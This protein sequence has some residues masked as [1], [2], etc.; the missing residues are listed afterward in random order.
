MVLL[1]S[2]PQLLGISP[3]GT[4][5]H[6][7]SLWTNA[8]DIGAGIVGAS[9]IRRVVQQIGIEYVGVSNFTLGTYGFVVLPQVLSGVSDISGTWLTRD[10]PGGA[11]VVGLMPSSLWDRIAT[12]ID[13][14]VS[15]VGLVDASPAHVEFVPGT[16][17]YLGTLS[18]GGQ[19]LVLRVIGP[20]LVAIVADSAILREQGFA[21][22]VILGVIDYTVLKD[23][24]WARQQDGTHMYVP[25]E[26]EVRA[27]ARQEDGT[28]VPVSRQSDGKQPYVCQEDGTQ[29]WR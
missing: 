23:E 29:Q 15:V 16:D 5:D 13:A 27:W 8:D 10:V 2:I 18:L 12:L 7:A 22:A 1:N 6:W 14:G 21:S 3:Q 19:S 11:S 17:N 25:Q 28:M 9:L 26:D 20:D 4:Y 24:L